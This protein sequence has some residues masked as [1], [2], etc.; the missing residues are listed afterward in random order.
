MAFDGEV[1]HSA[2]PPLPE[3]AQPR[4]TLAIKY[5]DGRDPK[6]QRHQRLSTERARELTPAGPKAS[7]RE[8]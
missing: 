6:V 1:Y 3:C 7:G 5:G 8:L 4:L 2:R